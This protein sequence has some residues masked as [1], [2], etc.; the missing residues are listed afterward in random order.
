M[1]DAVGDPREGWLARLL[2]AATRTVSS[3]P[4]MSLA[5]VLIASLLSLGVAARFLTLKTDRA[6]LIS[7]DAPFQKRW[8]NYTEKF[9]SQ[10]D[11]VVVVESESTDEVCQVL[12][13]LGSRLVD[14]P[15][16]FDRVAWRFDPQGLQAK[17]LQ[18]LTPKQLEEGLQRL[19]AYAPILDG[20]WNRAGLESYCRRLA[21]HIQSATERGDLEERDATLRQAARLCLSLDRFFQST[22]PAA[23]PQGFAPAVHLESNHRPD[24]QRLIETGFEVPSLAGPAPGLPSSAKTAIMTAA[25]T[26]Y[27]TEHGL[28]AGAQETQFHSPWPEILPPDARKMQQ[29]DRPRYYLS[30]DG[31]MGFIQTVPVDSGGNLSG[32]SPPVVRVRQIVAEVQEDYPQ[33][34]IG[35]TGIPI[36]ESDEMQ[37]SQSD[38]TTASIVSFVGV[39]LILLIGFR[40]LRHPMLA[41][42]M[43][44]VGLAWSLG[45]TTLAVGHLNILSVS[46]AAILIGLGVDF[47]IHY[48][49]RYLELRHQGAELLP[50]LQRTSSGVGT[51][52]VTAAVTTAVAFFCACF[53]SFLGVAELGIIAGGGILVCSAAT[54]L[55]LPALVAVADRNVEPRR[56]PNPFRGDLLRLAT[57]EHPVLVTIVTLG[58]ILLVGSQAIEFE[59]GKA[60]SRVTY[61]ANLLHLQAKGVDSVEVQNRVFQK[62]QAGLLYAVSI[63]KSPADARRLKE[64]FLELDTVLHVEELG[65][66]M[67]KYPSAET[68]LLVQAFHARLQNLSALPR[69]FPVIDPGSVGGAMESLFVAMHQA[70]TPE[71]RPATAALDKFL[72]S[73]EQVP[74]PQ[75]VELL[76]GY[77]YAMLTALRGQFEAIFAVSNPEPVSEHDLDPGTRDRFVS[78]NSEWLL[79]IYPREQVWDEEPLARFVADV[80]TID[81]DVTGTP[82]QN[83]EA[84][85]QIRESYFNAALL[86]LAAICMVLLIDALKTG[87]LIVS[88]LTPLIVVGYAM[89]TLQSPQEPL[90]VLMLIG[91][92]VGVAMAVAAIFDFSNVKNALLSLLPPIVGGILMFGILGGLD[93]QLNPANLIVLPLILGIG[94][95]DGVHVLHDFRMQRGDYRTSASTI[96]AITLTSLTSMVGFGSLML[97]SHQGLASLGLVLVVGVGSCLFVSLVLLPALLTLLHHRQ[98]FA[99]EMG[100]MSP[101]APTKSMNDD[102]EESE[103]S[104]GRRREQPRGLTEQRDDERDFRL[105]GNLPT[106][107]KMSTQSPDVPP[108]KRLSNAIY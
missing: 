12:D 88:L 3:R 84:A 68:Q 32:L 98:P 74:L 72:S 4:G 26:G 31:Q 60:T 33:V 91:I 48:L 34:R 104:I 22:M 77:Q 44:L 21:Q 90:N 83:Y 105:S 37:R 7:D 38:M 99:A 52:I 19:N 29:F 56:L 1:D 2:C 28:P 23:A 18:F 100:A 24:R 35:L 41:L 6:D 36:L 82:L 20:H 11:I 76:G 95:D 66:A 5:L 101:P 43:L 13:V 57:H 15:Q 14:E 103:A 96:N 70:D 40:G 80:R 92:Y 59:D 16:L 102:T 45:Y 79:R 47:A 61:D 107:S 71:T 53:T 39:G 85:R 65:S 73:L 106:S 8:A 55:V 93:V 49:A 54:F 86:A 30:E 58:A 94:V 87:P 75:Q 46:F 67:P 81:R 50:A 17:G 78:A 64:K 25:T 63:A 42:I 89:T 62:S 108:D 69:E 51:G 27:L 9:G 97:S 10:S